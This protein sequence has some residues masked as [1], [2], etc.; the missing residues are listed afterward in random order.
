MRNDEKARPARGQ[1]LL[2]PFLADEKRARHRSQR[3]DQHRPQPPDAQSAPTEDS[4]AY[5]RYGH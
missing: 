5:K 4:A 3:H 1:D 2:L